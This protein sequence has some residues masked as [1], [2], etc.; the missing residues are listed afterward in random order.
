MIILVEKV[1]NPKLLEPY[2]T[3]K[4]IRKIREL[5]ITTQVVTLKIHHV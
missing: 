4:K 3:S 5:Q 1:L 2:G